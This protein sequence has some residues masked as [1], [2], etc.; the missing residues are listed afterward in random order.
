MNSKSFVIRQIRYFPIEKWIARKEV[1]IWSSQ[2]PLNIGCKCD[3]GSTILIVY[4]LHAHTR[5]SNIHMRSAKQ[6]NVLVCMYF[7]FLFNFIY[8]STRTLTRTRTH[9]T[10]VVLSS[11]SGSSND[12][13]NQWMYNV[14]SQ[15]AVSWE[16]VFC[17]EAKSHRELEKERIFSIHNSIQFNSKWTNF[18]RK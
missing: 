15:S 13:D 9:C 14:N 17:C 8:T 6:A 12:D 3:N 10:V 7:F 5:H 16:F 2:I 4:V 18:W 1:L 11:S